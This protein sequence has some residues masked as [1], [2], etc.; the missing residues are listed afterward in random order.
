MIDIFSIG[1]FVKSLLSGR[2]LLLDVD[3]D[4]DYRWELYGGLEVNV[5]VLVK[6]L[7]F[8]IADYEENL[9]DYRLL[10][11]SYWAYSIYLPSIQK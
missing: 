7:N 10:L 3:P 4:A 11:T 2:E 1:Y 5:G 6:I 8:T 9:V